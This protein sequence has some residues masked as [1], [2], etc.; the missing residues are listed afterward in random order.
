MTGANLKVQ[1][2]PGTIACAG[3]W[4]GSIRVHDVERVFG[5]R[6]DGHELVRPVVNE[7]TQLRW[8]N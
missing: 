4:R 1:D 8:S 3:E 5:R 6:F 7:W 2:H